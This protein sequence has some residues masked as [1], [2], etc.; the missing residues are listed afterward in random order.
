MA[1]IVIVTEDGASAHLDC[2]RPDLEAYL[3]RALE[4]VA[5]WDR[6]IG[7]FVVP[8]PSSSGEVKW[9]E[10]LR[11]TGT[12]G[13]VTVPRE[14]A[15]IVDR[16]FLPTNPNKLRN[17]APGVKEAAHAFRNAVRGGRA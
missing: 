14:V 16:V 4:H 8:V 10:P 6:E 15:E 13:T 7:R 1:R 9:Y 17:A 5:L 3:R 12:K 11:A 2:F